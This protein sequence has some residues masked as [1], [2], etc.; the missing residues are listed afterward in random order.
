MV[1]RESAI[2]LAKFLPSTVPLS[3]QTGW[4]HALR[5]AHA[6]CGWASCSVWRAHTRGAHHATPRVTARGAGRRAARQLHSAAAA[7][8]GGTSWYSTPPRPKPAAWGQARRHT[9]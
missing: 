7:R 9:A 5:T 4:S 1:F 2:L 3:R 6:F 8:H